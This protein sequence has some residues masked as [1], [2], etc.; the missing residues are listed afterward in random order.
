MQCQYSKKNS[1]LNCTCQY[2]LLTVKGIL[3]ES[4]FMIWI[5]AITFY[6][7]PEK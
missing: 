3:V 4:I 2:Y 7:Q 5:N 1:L 6:F